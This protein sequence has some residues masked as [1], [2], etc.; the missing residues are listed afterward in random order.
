MTTIRV[1]LPGASQAQTQ[2]EVTRPEIETHIRVS[3]ATGGHRTAKF[4]RNQLDRLNDT[5]SK[6]GRA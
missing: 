6:N 5:E 3:E 1:P 2:I 4:W